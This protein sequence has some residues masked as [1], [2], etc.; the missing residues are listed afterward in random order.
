MY[1]LNLVSN[2][3]YHQIKPLEVTNLALSVGDSAPEFMGEDQFGNVVRLGSFK[4]KWN[5]VMVF[6]P[7][8]WS[9]ISMMLMS[10]FQRSLHLFNKIGAKIIGISVDSVYS[11]KEWSRRHCLEFTLISDFSRRI[12]QDYE[13][14]DPKGFAKPSIFVLDKNGVVKYIK[15]SQMGEKPSAENILEKMRELRINGEL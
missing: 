6:Y 12:S 13:V 7:F 10:D 5:L 11:H 1:F 14:L 3:T 15:H 2:I 9:P 8:D 4:G